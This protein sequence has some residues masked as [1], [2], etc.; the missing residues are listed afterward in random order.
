MTVESREFLFSGMLPAWA[1][2]N[3]TSDFWVI[4]ST[5]SIDFPIPIGGTIA[6]QRLRMSP[7]S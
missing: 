2:R 4:T 3:D 6:A 5:A 7:P 1:S